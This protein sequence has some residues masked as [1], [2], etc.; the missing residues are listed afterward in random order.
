MS[1]CVTSRMPPTC[2]R[3][4]LGLRLK[5]QNT[6]GLP[7]SRGTLSQKLTFWRYF[8]GGKKRP[9]TSSHQAAATVWG[10]GQT[11]HALTGSLPE[12]MCPIGEPRPP[13]PEGQA[14]ADSQ[15]RAR[16]FPGETVYTQCQRTRNS[17]KRSPSPR[18]LLTRSLFLERNCLDVSQSTKNNAGALGKASRTRKDEESSTEPCPRASS[19][20]PAAPG[21]CHRPC[22]APHPFVFTVP[23]CPPVTV[24]VAPSPADRRCFLSILGM[25]QPYKCAPVRNA[26]LEGFFSAGQEHTPGDHP[27]SLNRQSRMV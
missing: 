1:G 26:A 27:E 24:P 5:T 17:D 15:V 13:L 4:D 14:R 8:Y 22:P 18:P 7:L 9:P 23:A 21:S 20:I 19:Q 16:H 2:L 25:N 3:S 12:S 10:W 11:G 6:A